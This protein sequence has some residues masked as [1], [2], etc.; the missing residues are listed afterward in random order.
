MSIECVPVKFEACDKD[1]KDLIFTVE[2]FD[3]A[4]ATIDIKVPVDL[5]LWNEISAHITAAIEK[6]E[7]IK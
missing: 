1:T 4:G 2:C 7:L 6:M 3:E 5:Q